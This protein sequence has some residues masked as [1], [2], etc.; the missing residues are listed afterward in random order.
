MRITCLLIA[1]AVHLGC[2]S[3]P[4]YEG[5]SDPFARMIDVIEPIDISPTDRGSIVPPH[6]A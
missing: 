2:E 5:D 1:C 6:G 4:L 3:I